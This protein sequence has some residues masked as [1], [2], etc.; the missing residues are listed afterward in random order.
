MFEWV[1]VQDL[2][3]AKGLPFADAEGQAWA[4]RSCDAT[5]AFITRRRP[6]L[7]AAGTEPT[8]PAYADVRLGA[9]LLAQAVYERRGVGAES[10]IY[11]YP[12]RLLDANVSE[13]LG[14]NRPV[15]A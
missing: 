14:L 7:P 2:A 5:N 9:V 10:D 11:T 13:L 12:A 6:D 1:T 3:D 8:D 4:V 15:V